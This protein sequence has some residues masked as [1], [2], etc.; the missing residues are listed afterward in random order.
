M[1]FHVNHLP[2]NLHKMSSLIFSEKSCLKKIK[3]L[4][5]AVVTRALRVNHCASVVFNIMDNMGHHK[6]ICYLGHKRS[7][8][9]EI[10]VY[11]MVPL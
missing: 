5:I 10:Q 3:M 8:F 4:T 7:I 2:E 1:A 9:K 6:V 11:M